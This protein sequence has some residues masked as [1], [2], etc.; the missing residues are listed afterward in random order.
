MASPLITVTV[1]STSGSFTDRY[2]PNV[3]AKVVFNRALRD[4]QLA[5]TA[6]RLT[7]GSGNTLDLSETLA[8]LG[9]ADGGTLFLQPLRKPQDG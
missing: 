2:N 9:V 3:P 8:D 4:L 5:G 7:T 6:Y 1:S